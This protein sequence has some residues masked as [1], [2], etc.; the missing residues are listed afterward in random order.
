LTTDEFNGKPTISYRTVGLSR[1]PVPGANNFNLRVFDGNRGLSAL[2]MSSVR[3]DGYFADADIDSLLRASYSYG[4]Q[5]P[6]FTA[7]TP[8]SSETSDSFIH[9]YKLTLNPLDVNNQLSFNLAKSNGYQQDFVTKK[10]YSFEGRKQIL[11]TFLNGEYA[12]D[13]KYTSSL[14]GIR[15][16][17]GAFGTALNFRQINKNFTTITGYP[18]NQ[19]EVG[20]IWSSSFDADKISLQ[21]TT[22]VY[23]QYLFYNPDNPEAL[24]I[25]SSASLHFPLVKSVWSDLNIYYVSTPGEI[26]PRTT[27]GLNERI[28]KSFNLLGFNNVSTY[29]GGAFQ[30]NRYQFSPSSEYDRWTF[31]TGVQVPLTTRLSAYV[32]YDDSWVHEIES[33]NDLNP[34]TVDT[35][36]HYSREIIKNLNGNFSIFYRK[37]MGVDGT[38]SYLSGED[39]AGASLGFTY[40]PIQ[41]VNLFFDARTRKVW[42]QLEGNY[43]NYDMDIRFGFRMSFDVLTRGWDPNGRIRGHVYKDKDGKGIYKKDYQGLPGIK[44]KAGE[45]EVTTDKE[46]FYRMDVRAKSV[47]VTPVSESLPP[48]VVFST[49]I[50]RSVDVKQWGTSTVDFGL[51]SQTGVYGLIFVDKNSNGVPDSGDEFIK[52]VKVI[53]DKKYT[54]VSDTQGAFYFRNIAEGAHTVRVDI[55]S[56]PLDI[57]PQIKLESK[58]VVA[59]GV[60]YLFHVPLKSKNTK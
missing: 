28:S 12:N 53:L 31:S 11:N 40:N 21:T 58:I 25:D 8:S 44:I 3:L 39:S 51:N 9:A 24:N 35:G 15:W 10:V 47:S 45:R 2:T 50:V 1:I 59:E 17:E 42:P 37:E 46:G 33:R 49:P 7:L 55:N 56:I 27:V 14:T 22:N 18:S 57:I 6:F 16:K 20:A 19:G 41:D 30:K 26:S 43:T 32:N 13:S 29:V 60:T 38:S 34:S 23:R 54:S 48:G 4:K 5:K 52:N 36:F